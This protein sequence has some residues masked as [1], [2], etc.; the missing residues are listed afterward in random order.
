M[1]PELEK[2]LAR[3]LQQV[4]EVVCEP[5]N[6]LKRKVLMETSLVMLADVFVTEGSEDD[7]FDSLCKK[8]KGFRSFRKNQGEPFGKGVPKYIG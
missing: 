8:L 4:I 2:A 6:E 5:N 3:S 7:A 1:S